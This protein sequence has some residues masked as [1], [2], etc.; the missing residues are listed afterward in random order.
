MKIEFTGQDKSL[1]K[2]MGVQTI[3][4]FGSQ[5]T[6][7]ENSLSDFD[8]GVLLKEKPGAKARLKVYSEM[9]EIITEALPKE[10]LERRFELR[11]HEFDLVFLQCAPPNLQLKAFQ[12]GLVLYD[13]DTKARL[14]YEEH[15]LDRVA[16]F[17]YFMK[18]Q[19]KALF[20]RI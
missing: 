5:V 12:E 14:S 2:E 19:E 7:E 10:Y 4:L 18:L 11:E 6:G 15:I 17:Q 3:Y 1:F 9:Y 13:Q 20:Q 8:F 16:D